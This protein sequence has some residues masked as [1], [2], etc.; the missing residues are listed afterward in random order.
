[1]ERHSKFRALLQ[2]RGLWL[3]GALLVIGAGAL[4]YHWVFGKANFIYATATVERG[5]SLGLRRYRLP[6]PRGDHRPGAARR[7][8][9]GMCQG[10]TTE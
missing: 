9:P 3:I 8:L 7:S 5:D 2:R 10:K 4:V 1:M 6:R